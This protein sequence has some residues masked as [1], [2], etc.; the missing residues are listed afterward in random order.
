MVT[1]QIVERPAFYSELEFYEW[2]LCGETEPFHREIG[3]R[4]KKTDVSPFN[5]DTHEMSEQSY[6]MYFIFSLIYMFKYEKRANIC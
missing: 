1:V 3:E 5:N 6:L 4:G 2:N